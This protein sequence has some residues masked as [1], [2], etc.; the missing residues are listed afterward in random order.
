MPSFE[1]PEDFLAF[2]FSGE[3]VGGTASALDSSW[4]TRP[5]PGPGF[6]TA[7]N[8]FF[9]ET[10]MRF[11]TWITVVASLIAPAGCSS[12]SSSDVKDC[13]E[14]KCDS[15]PDSE[16]PDS[17]CDGVIKDMSG[18]GNQKVAGRLND[19]FAQQVMNTGNR[20][21]TNF[22]DII[23]KF[24][25]NDKFD[26]DDDGSTTPVIVTE[27]V[28]ETA[29]ALGKPTDYRSVTMTRCHN[30]ARHTTMFT[31]SGIKVGGPIPDAVQII[32]IDP[33]GV[34]NFY[35]ADGNHL[36]YFGNSKDM[37]K[38]ADGELRKCAT[39][40]VSGGYVMREMDYP[41]VHWDSD[42]ARLPGVHE[43]LA[44]HPEWGKDDNNGDDG[45]ERVDIESIDVAG[46]TSLGNE[47]WNQTRRR[48]LKTQPSGVKE[49]LRPL[50]CTME[51]NIQ[52]G[53]ENATPVTGGPDPN[54]RPPFIWDI[55]PEFSLISEFWR[56]ITGIDTVGQIPIDPADY[57]ELIKT[58]GQFIPGI[59]GAI[60]TIF[61]YAF[62]GRAEIDL[63]LVDEM[64]GRELDEALA[65]DVIMV[66]FTRPVFSEDRC[67]L[68]EFA[69]DIQGE[70]T[71]EV[72]RAGFVANLE[73]AAPAEGTPAAVLLANL[74][75]T[76]DTT[77]HKARLGAFTHACAAL[78]SRPSVPGP[79][80]K[81]GSRSPRV[82]ATSPAGGRS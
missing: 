41:N 62:I 82:I 54:A 57:D 24:E 47:V 75:N 1:V 55:F 43:L 65:I 69:P 53:N 30:D 11:R 44:A 81:T 52:V 21:P 33:G 60:D 78:G 46:A 36:T 66:D 76:D 34:F 2:M 14:G 45:E 61:D 29:Q 26:C 42:R 71:P 23:K 4:F 6:V 77:A 5:L 28:S 37:L 58:N 18:R 20:C 19:D 50:F 35:E 48:Y 22:S 15:L 67:D 38:G 68:L 74:K 39:C 73:K 10:D 8:P 25:K 7:T 79:C 40:H 3:L 9:L 49:L 51:F 63:D 27:F 64:M 17:P 80:S 59:P 32:S 16:V 70:I 56:P 13:S 31:Q 72:I 12:S